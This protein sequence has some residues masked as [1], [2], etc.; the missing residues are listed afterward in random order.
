MRCHILTLFPGMVTPVLD[1]SILKRAQAKGLL[2]VRVINIRDF[3]FDKHRSADDYP[4]GGGAGMVLKAEPVLKAV[5]F[6]KEEDEE[7]LRILLMSPQGKRYNQGMASE[8]S[9]EERRIVFICGH[10]EG[11]DERVKT[12]LSP[13]EVSIGDY[14][15]TGGELAALV[16]IDSVVRLIPGVLGDSASVE[17]ESFNQLLDYPHY[18]R[19]AQLREMDVPSILISGNHEVIRQWRRRQAVANT[20]IKR[21]DILEGAVLSDEDMNILKEIKEESE[22]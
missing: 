8:L 12:Y 13:E 4:Y 10:Y 19:P 20:L 7:D 21:P 2:N 17:D 5:D 22:K 6:I 18:T 11:I 3:T 15:L 16:I 9:R 14:V 1:E